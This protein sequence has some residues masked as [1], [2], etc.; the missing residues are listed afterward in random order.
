MITKN[1]ETIEKIEKEINEYT[2]TNLLQKTIKETKRNE[3]I[4]TSIEWC[5]AWLER[6]KI[7]KLGLKRKEDSWT[8]KTLLQ[9]EEDKKQLQ[10]HLKWLKQK[11]EELK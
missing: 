5:E 4:Q 7:M 2:N 11:E 3:R 6:L 1:K 10:S 8:F 9:I